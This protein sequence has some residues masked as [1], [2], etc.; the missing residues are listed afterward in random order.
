MPNQYFPEIQFISDD[1]FIIIVIEISFFQIYILNVSSLQLAFFVRF[2]FYFVHLQNIS[3]ANVIIISVGHRVILYPSL[4]TLL[5][6][7]N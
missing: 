7:A 5:Y 1:N 3:F 2:F 4:K 6:L